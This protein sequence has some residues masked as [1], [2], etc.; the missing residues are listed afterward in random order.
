MRQSRLG[1]TI[2][3][4]TGDH[5]LGALLDE[6]GELLALEEDV[7]VVAQVTPGPGSWRRRSARSRRAAR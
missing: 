1:Q 7:E 6:H 5:Y 3:V 4:A 2:L